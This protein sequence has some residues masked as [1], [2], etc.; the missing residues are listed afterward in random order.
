MFEASGSDEQIARHYYELL[1]GRGCKVFV[2]VLVVLRVRFA[3]ERRVSQEEC[4]LAEK[5]LQGVARDMQLSPELNNNGRQT[6]PLWV[7]R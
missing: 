6:L 1:L 5:Y 4:P 7:F 3:F 2:G